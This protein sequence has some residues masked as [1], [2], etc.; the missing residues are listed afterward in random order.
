MFK[1]ISIHRPIWMGFDDLKHFYDTEKDE[2]KRKDR[3]GREARQ[4]TAKVT[5]PENVIN[6]IITPLLASTFLRWL[7]EARTPYPSY[8]AT[9]FFFCRQL[10]LRKTPLISE[11]TIPPKLPT[12]LSVQS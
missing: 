1:D 3:E 8:A 5:K 9:C 7:D 12:E 10:V 11:N 4:Q 2:V 6:R